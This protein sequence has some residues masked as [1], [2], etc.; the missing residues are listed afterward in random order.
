MATFV[1]IVSSEENFECFLTIFF[2]IK[3]ENYCNGEMYGGIHTVIY[4]FIGKLLKLQ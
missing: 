1:F 3:G 2:T 4:V